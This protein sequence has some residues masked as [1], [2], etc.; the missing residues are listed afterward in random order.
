[1]TILARSRLRALPRRLRR[2]TSGLALT[3]FAYSLPILLAL[4]LYGFETA[5]LAI[6]HMRISNMAMLAAD[7]GLTRIP[8]DPLLCP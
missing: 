2:C 5:H 6:A 7:I 8:A 4:G 1:M 3:E